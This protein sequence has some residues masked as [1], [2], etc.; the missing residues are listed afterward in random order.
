MPNAGAKEPG[1]RLFRRMNRGTGRENACI[2][3][4]KGRQRR[5]QRDF[6]QGAA[7]AERGGSQTDRNNLI[8]I[9]PS[10][11][12]FNT[13]GQK[14]TKSTNIGTREAESVLSHKKSN[15]VREPLR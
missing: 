10:V 6:L 3:P 13:A 15:A 4:R 11:S 1:H 9:L 12:C 5:R 8:I 2:I 14:H 7:A